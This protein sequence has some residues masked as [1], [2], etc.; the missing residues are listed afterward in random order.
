MSSSRAA[1]GFPGKQLMPTPQ[2]MLE[3]LDSRHDELIH[4]LDELNAQIEAALQQFTKA[5]SEANPA[6]EA[7]VEAKPAERRLRRAA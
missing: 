5:R 4:K 1:F 3:R 2:E 7:A 6:Q